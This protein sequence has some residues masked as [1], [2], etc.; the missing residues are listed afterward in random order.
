MAESLPTLLGEIRACRLCEAELPLGANPVLRAKSSARLLIVGQA[1]GVKVHDSGIPWNDAS[2]IRLRHWMGL[3]REH[4]YNERD[5]AIVP[6]GFCYP[7][8]G[9]AGDLPPRPECARTWH[10]RLLPLLPNI[11]LTLLIG[12]YAQ[13][14][15]LG[16]RRKKTLT[17]TV[18]AYA[19]YMPRVIPLPH[20]SPRNQLWLKMNPWFETDLVPLLRGEV[21]ALLRPEVAR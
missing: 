11:E 8:R 17:D 13:A 12:H 1:P 20:P 19:Q 7:G 3:D 15:M 4:F 9:S 10:P 6:M 5:V 21:A 2:G 14:F 18:R 16:D